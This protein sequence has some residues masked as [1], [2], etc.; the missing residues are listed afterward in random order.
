MST[1][2]Y[3][4]CPFCGKKNAQCK[5]SPRWGYFVA[6][7]CKATGTPSDSTQ[8]AWDNWNR[9]VPPEQGRLL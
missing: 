4:A 8:G 2:D 6:C 1:R 3:E 9:R 5:H 7:V